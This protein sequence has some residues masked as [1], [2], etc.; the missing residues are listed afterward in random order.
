MAG[1][2]SEQTCTRS[3]KIGKG[4]PS[5]LHPLGTLGFYMEC[6]AVPVATGV[7]SSSCGR[8]WNTGGAAVQQQLQHLLLGVPD[9]TPSGLS[10]SSGLCI[11]ILISS[12]AARHP[13]STLTLPKEEKRGTMKRKARAHIRPQINVGSDFQAELPELQSKPP[14][15]D[16]EPA[17]LVWKPWEE[18][19]SDM[20]KPDRVRELLDMAS[21]RGFPKAAANLEL[22][23]HCLHQAR[24]SVPEALEMLLSGGPPTP[25]G[26]PLADYHY[27]DSVKWTPEEKESFQKAFHTYGKDFHLIQKQ[28]PSKTVAQCV[29]YYYSWKKEHKLAHT[30]AQAVCNH[31]GKECTQEKTSPT[32]GSRASR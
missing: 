7:V 11:H 17:S 16:E 3:S 9:H 8:W 6:W 19:D 20:D 18:D 10:A 21:S 24:G 1:R 27:A 25:Q 26:H 14:S 31:E 4:G 23:L 30:L 13:H 2:C 15:D 32:E 29:E 12:S 22:A 5:C 28:I